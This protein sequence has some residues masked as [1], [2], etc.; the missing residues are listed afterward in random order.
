MCG[1]VTGIILA[2]CRDFMVRAGGPGCG[3]G[4]GGITC[5]DRLASLL[6]YLK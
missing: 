4:A 1:V 2:S 6:I 5:G 3:P